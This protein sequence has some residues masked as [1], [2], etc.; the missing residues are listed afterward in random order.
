MYYCWFGID[1][2]LILLKNKL[3]RNIIIPKKDKILTSI[4]KQIPK[5]HLSK[6]KK[7]LKPFFCVVYIAFMLNE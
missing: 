5:V 6:K 7:K 2:F 4:L 3:S 1:Y